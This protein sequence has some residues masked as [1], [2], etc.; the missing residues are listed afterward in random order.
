MKAEA[1]KPRPLAR[2]APVRAVALSALVLALAAAAGAAV[3][4]APGPLELRG[5]TR[6][7]VDDARGLWT[8]LGAPVEL[9]RGQLRLRAPRLRYDVRA[10]VVDAEGGV[11]AAAPGVEA[12]AE[13]AALRL[14]DEWLRADGDVRLTATQGAVPVR[15][16]APQVEG[17][18]R[19]RR[20][21]AT[22]GVTV[23]RGEATLQGHRVDYD[24]GTRRA[25]VTGDP[26]LRVR[27]ALLTAQTLVL[28]VDED[29]VTGEGGVRVRRGDLVATAARADL[30]LRDGVA[31]LAGNARAQRGADVITAAELVVALDGSSVVARGAPRLTITPP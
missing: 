4:A 2:R 19:T 6:V 13:R 30:R 31:T 27:E 23:V 10:G 25:V 14:D 11:D 8:V 16:R 29:R 3:P 15:M 9:V 5:A 18:L 28:L 17:S 7:E 1:T 24:D 12:H 21:V 22:G 20:F 26:A